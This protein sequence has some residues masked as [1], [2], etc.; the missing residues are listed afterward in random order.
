MLNDMLT[1]RMLVP[2]TLA[3]LALAGCA[4]HQRNDPAVA[5]ELPPTVRVENDNT[6]DMK[7]YLIRGGQRVRIGTANALGV[8]MLKLPPTVINGVTELR[9]LLVPIGGNRAEL[10]EKIT[11]NPGEEIVLRILPG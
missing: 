11:A 9:F 3:V 5:P 8:T 10:S 4:G 6:S 7:V 1:R 2:A